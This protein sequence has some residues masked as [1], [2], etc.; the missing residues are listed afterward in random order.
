MIG[1]IRGLVSRL[2]VME[3]FVAGIG[4]LYVNRIAGHYMIDDEMWSARSSRP[5][6]GP[7]RTGRGLSER[8]VE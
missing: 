7:P 8:P 5:S 1:K 4:P 6:P 3:I 2:P